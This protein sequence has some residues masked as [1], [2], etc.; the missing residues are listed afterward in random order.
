[1]IAY[2]V[3]RLAYGFLTVL[4]VLLLLFIL[5]FTVTEP[6]DIARKALGERVPPEAIA[7]WIV[8]HGYDKP[9]LVNTNHAISDAK[10]YSDTLLFEHYRRM[11]GFDFGRSDAD[12][13]PYL[14]P[15]SRRHRTQPQPDI[16]AVHTGV[17]RRSGAGFVRGVFQRNLYRPFGSGVVHACDE[18]CSP[19]SISSA[20]NISSA[21]CSN[22]S[23]FQALTL[24][25]RWWRVFL[26]FLC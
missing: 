2:L 12:D 22:G 16:T 4:G 10:R 5:F 13:T 23:R 24:T 26:P 20:G 3:R 21:C 11:L 7:Q 18:Y 19:C 8:N 1:M 15:H 6:K 14:G 25:H 17:A 9:A